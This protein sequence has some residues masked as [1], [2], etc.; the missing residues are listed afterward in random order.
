MI[1]DLP[2]TLTVK[3]MAGYNPKVLANRLGFIDA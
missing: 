2:V 1:P 3:I